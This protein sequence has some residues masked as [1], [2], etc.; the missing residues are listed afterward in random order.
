MIHNL[1]ISK[2]ILFLS[3]V[4]VGYNACN[5]ASSKNSQYTD[6]L[7]RQDTLGKSIEWENVKKQYN[8]NITA[9]AK[10]SNDN[11]ARLKLT[12]LYL[13]EARIGGNQSY[14]YKATLQ[15]INHL[16]SKENITKDDRFMALT[17]KSS[18]LLSLHQFADAK[19]TAEEAVM[20]NPYNADIYGALVDA[21]VEMGNYKEAVEL[22]DKM[23]SIRPD[24]R[25]YSRASYIRQIYGDNDG[26]KAAM[27]MAVDAG[28]SGYEATEWAR[29][30]LGDLYLNTGKYDTAKY[31]YESALIYRPNYPYAEIGLAKLARAQKQYD[32]A[33]VH[34]ERAIRVLSE[35]SFVTMLAELNEL[36]G[37][38]AKATEIHNDVLKLLQE[39][40]KEN[41]KEL[42]ARHNGYRELATGYMHAGKLNEALSYAQKDLAMRPENI[43]ANELVAWIYFLKNDAT[44]AKKHIDKALAT[45]VKNANTLYKAYI[46]YN[47]NA[48][49][50]RALEL[51]ESALAINSN[52]DALLS[53]IAVKAQ[54]AAK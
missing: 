22:C 34:C 12:A 20:I 3:I 23:L 42:V 33:I 9:I 26:A 5:T 52:I 28:P 43:D 4:I 49:M 2:I 53:G 18:V 45:N 17:Y 30:N 27:K 19:K 25:S 35:S 13:N 31:M 48:D 40:E 32:S 41:E 16:L 38:V 39:G 15:M 47:A 36:K 29:V 10:D 37:D 8:D 50:I 46:I 6:L 21:N 44:N 14:Y 1:K 11:N 51:K 54:V 24:L 7:E